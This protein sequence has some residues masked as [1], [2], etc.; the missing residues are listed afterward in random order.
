[1]ALKHDTLRSPLLVYCPWQQVGHQS[2]FNAL[3]VLSNITE[4]I[5]TSGLIGS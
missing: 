5:S 1:M 3:M 4:I 2:T